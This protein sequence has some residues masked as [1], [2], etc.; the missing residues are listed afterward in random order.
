MRFNTKIASFAAAVFI[1]IW[2]FGYSLP[3]TIN[4]A[5][6]LFRNGQ[7]YND[8]TWLNSQTIQYLIQHPTLGSE[9]AIYTNAPD[10]VY[11]LANMKANSIPA[12]AG[13]AY[14]IEKSAFNA[15]DW[16]TDAETC[17]VWFDTIDRKFM[18]SLEGLQAAA[19]INLIVRLEDG[20][21]YS[22]TKK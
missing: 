15:K 11:L 21:I 22:V 5:F 19:N 17:L 1:A 20:A 4:N 14:G 2:A 3:N 18:L 8:R 12:R 13:R 16:V 10:V 9:C 6:A 7:G